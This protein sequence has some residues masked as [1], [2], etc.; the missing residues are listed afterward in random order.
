MES[1]DDSSTLRSSIRSRRSSR[2]S[3]VNNQA[4]DKRRS[5]RGRRSSMSV[6]EVVDGIEIIKDV[7]IGDDLT[8]VNER[9]SSVVSDKMA[10]ID[11]EKEHLVNYMKKLKNEKEEWDNILQNYAKIAD[12]TKRLLCFLE[13]AFDTNKDTCSE[14]N[15]SIVLNA[16]RVEEVRIEYIGNR[17]AP[18]SIEIALAMRPALQKR[19][20]LQVSQNEKLKAEVAAAEERFRRLQELIKIQGKYLNYENKDDLLSQKAECDATLLR[21]EN[22]MAKHGFSKRLFEAVQ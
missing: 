19:A 9:N 5:L 20:E 7:I 13:K 15:K 11:E 21:I 17:N 4:S 6:K 16:K 18:S 8:K 3:T 14:M 10:A 2:L 12:V 22:W 1:E